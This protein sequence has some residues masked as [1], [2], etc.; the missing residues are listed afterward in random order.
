M[1]FKRKKPLPYLATEDT[2]AD[3]WLLMR[4][5][6]HLTSR[7]RELELSQYDLSP[8]QAAVLFCAQALGKKAT[9]AQISRQLIR[10][11]HSMSGLIT[12]MEEDGLVKRVKDLD[13]K[14]LVRVALTNKGRRAHHQAIK[15]ESIHRIYSVLSEKEREQM[16]SYLQ[17]LWDSTQE[18]MIR[19]S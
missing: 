8:I 10:Q 7:A 11:P 16:M 13:K 2:N 12:R 14:N 5:V 18:A 19:G 6:C 17:R 4:R 1:R 15:R 3:L 9:I